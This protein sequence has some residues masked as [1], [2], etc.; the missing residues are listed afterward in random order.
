MDPDF[1]KIIPTSDAARLQAEDQEALE[2]E[3]QEEEDDE[4]LEGTSDLKP[5]QAAVEMDTETFKARGLDKRSKAGTLVTADSSETSSENG[6]VKRVSTK[7]PEE[8]LQAKFV[9]LK[10]A[11]PEIPR[12]GNFKIDEIMV[13]ARFELCEIARRWQRA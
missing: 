5:S 3:N 13:S 12:K 7:N 2:M 6:K 1:E 4:F 8:Y 10:D 9:L 11:I